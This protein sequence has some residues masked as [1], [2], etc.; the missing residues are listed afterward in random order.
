M[1]PDRR[2]F[3]AGGLATTMLAGLPACTTV[4]QA[5]GRSSF[6]GLYSPEDDIKLGRQEHPKLVKEFGG[7]YDNP[8][9]QGYIAQTGKRLAAGTEYQQ[10]PYQFTLLNTPIVN[11]FALPGGYVYISRGLL[12]LASNE[13]EMAGVA[14]DAPVEVQGPF[15][16]DPHSRRFA[17]TSSSVRAISTRSSD[18]PSPVVPERKRTRTPRRS[19][20]PIA[21]A[22]A[23]RSA[24]RSIL[25]SATISRRS[26]KSGS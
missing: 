21:G 20:S 23:S 14:L 26:S 25:L 18:S 3:L 1:T 12:A 4:N 22:R 10:Y 15:A 7:E 24:T 11:A 16:H 13:A 6:T 17:S 2:Q 8:R 19:S 9:L 5:T